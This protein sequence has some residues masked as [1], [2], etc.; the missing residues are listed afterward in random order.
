V[1]LIVGEATSALEGTPLSCP[2]GGTCSS[3]PLG[4]ARLSCPMNRNRLSTVAPRTRQARPSESR[5]ANCREPICKIGEKACYTQDVNV[6]YNGS[7]LPLRKICSEF[8][9]IPDEMGTSGGMA[10][11]F[12]P[13]KRNI[14]GK[15]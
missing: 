5:R 1:R 7:C 3:R 15:V 13:S 4:G 11:A 2:F 9:K 8:V 6:G 14:N 10:L 12:V